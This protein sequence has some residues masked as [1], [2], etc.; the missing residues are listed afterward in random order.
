MW[1]NHRA[2]KIKNILTTCISFISHSM[3]LSKLLEHG[4]NALGILSLKM[5]LRLVKPILLS[6]LERL[7]RIYSFAKFMSMT[8][9][10]VLLTNPFCDEFTKIMT[11]RFE[12]SMM[13][14]LK[15]FLEFQI[16]QLEDGTFLSQ[17][18][19]A[20]D[21]LKKFGMD[22]A[23]PIKTPIGTNGHI[24]LNMVGKLVDQK[25]YH[26]IIASL[27]YLCASR[28]DIIISVCMCARFQA[29][30]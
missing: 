26:S 4:M 7:T 9:Y 22:K 3:G 13:G 6:S 16:K 14:E 12:I 17:T 28:P 20:R 19:Y 27:L 15:F 5:V 2:L 29:A 10:L 23:N 25:V 11:D 24:D 21:I 8:Q 30:P 18:K 1:S